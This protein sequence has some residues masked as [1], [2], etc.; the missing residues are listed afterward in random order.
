MSSKILP[1][2]SKKRQHNLSFSKKINKLTS[3]VIQRIAMLSLKMVLLCIQNTKKIIS[4]VSKYK[5][6]WILM[7]VTINSIL[8]WDETPCNLVD[9]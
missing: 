6:F 5:R 1:K 8:L 2:F 7:G 3:Y 9:K 4:L